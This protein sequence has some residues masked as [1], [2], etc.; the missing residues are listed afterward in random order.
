MSQNSE[1]HRSGSAIGNHITFIDRELTMTRHEMWDAMDNG[2][3][4]G[5]IQE[6]L[7]IP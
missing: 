3:T 6:M 4:S 7:V 1:V 5:F 2:I